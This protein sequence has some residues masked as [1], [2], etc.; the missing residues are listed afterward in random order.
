MFSVVKALPNHDS[1]LCKLHDSQV[2][3]LLPKKYA[4]REFRIGESNFAAVFNI[5]KARVTLSQV[6]FYYTRRILEYLLFPALK[7]LKLKI[8]KSAWIAAA[9]YR[10]VAV[11]SLNGNITDSF[12]LPRAQR[13]FFERIDLKVL[14]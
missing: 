11:E 13:P 8:K 4:R 6:S 3:A 12:Q 14:Q 5:E 7:E 10:K 9:R 2:F 1:Y